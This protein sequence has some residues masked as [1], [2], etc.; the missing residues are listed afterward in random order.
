MCHYQTITL[1]GGLVVQAYIGLHLGIL[2]I[3]ITNSI[4][5]VTSVLPWQMHKLSLYLSLVMKELVSE[6]K[7]KIFSQG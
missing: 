6:A 5:A 2:G 1:Y 7:D 4:A 3:L